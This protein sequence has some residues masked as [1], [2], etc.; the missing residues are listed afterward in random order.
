MLFSIPSISFFFSFKSLMN[1]CKYCMLA[2]SAASAM[3]VS[4]QCL[5][6]L[7]GSQELLHDVDDGLDALQ[8]ALDL[9]HR[10]LDVVERAVQTVAVAAGGLVERVEGAEE[11]VDAAAEMLDD[12]RR[13][14]VRRRRHRVLRVVSEV[15]R[16]GLERALRRR[17]QDVAHLAHQVVGVAV[18]L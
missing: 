18:E 12:L 11:A 2:S 16:E 8:H 3:C 7:N 9:V 14:D 10:P 17:L 4:P 15:A 13:E 1:E 6:G 5:D